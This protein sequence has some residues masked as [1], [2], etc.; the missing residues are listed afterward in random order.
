M[1]F[2]PEN[3]VFCSKFFV[4]KCHGQNVTEFTHLPIKSKSNILKYKYMKYAFL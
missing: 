1:A 4:E 3:N 2:V